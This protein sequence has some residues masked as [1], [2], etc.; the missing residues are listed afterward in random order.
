MSRFTMIVALTGA[1]LAG[2]ATAMAQTAPT[3]QF[4][5]RTS[6]G[7]YVPSTNDPGCAGLL[8]NP[9]PSINA[10]GGPARNPSE[11][12]PPPACQGLLC[13]MTPYSMQRPYTAAEAAEV[14]RQRAAAQ[15]QIAAAP[16]PE[17]AAPVRHVRKRRKV[18]RA[19]PAKAAAAKAAPVKAAP[20]K[21]AAAKAAPVAAHRTAA[22]VA[23]APRTAAP[24]D[25][26]QSLR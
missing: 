18:A 23:A 7:G 13:S 12:A 26:V 15:A 14:E 10:A 9:L 24:V 17:A 16:P 22:P 5:Q 4:G 21:A 1:L 8:C 20:V 6:G 11:V 25:D 3:G 2:A 19:A